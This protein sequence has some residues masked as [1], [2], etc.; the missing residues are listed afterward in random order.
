[1][2]GHTKARW[3]VVT[4]LISMALVPAAD[5]T[6]WSSAAAERSTMR[7]VETAAAPAE[8]RVPG[9]HG[10]IDQLWRPDMRAAVAYA[11]TRVGDIAFAVRTADRFYGYRPDHVEWSASVVKAMLMVAHLDR[12]AVADRPLSSRDNSLL[13]PMITASDNGAA[14]QVDEIVGSGGLDA[15]ARRV[16]MTHFQA[17]APVWGETHITRGT[18]P[19]SSCTSTGTW[20]RATAATPCICSRRSS[21]PSVGGSGNCHN[22]GGRSISR[23]DGAM[24]PVCSTTRWS[25]SSATVRSWPSPC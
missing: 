1:M 2:S 21:P 7:T 10:T 11:R 25:F 12:P 9:T 20:S 19:A 4:T 6:T 18:R 15:L 8:C 22:G 24:E 14:D 17:V 23:G 5:P 13:S 16:G 3:F